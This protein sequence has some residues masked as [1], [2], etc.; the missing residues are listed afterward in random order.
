ME[1]KGAA[2]ILRRFFLLYKKHGA[3]KIA[4]RRDAVILFSDDTDG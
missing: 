1:Y 4:V 3:P 2:D